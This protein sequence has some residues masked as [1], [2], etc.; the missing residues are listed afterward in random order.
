MIE[1]LNGLISCRHVSGV[2]IHNLVTID[3]GNTTVV[4]IV[5]VVG[6]ID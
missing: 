5:D 3:R 4:L 6:K 2:I 1:N